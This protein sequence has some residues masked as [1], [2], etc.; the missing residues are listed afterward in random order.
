MDDLAAV[1]VLASALGMMGYSVIVEDRR[2]RWA[3]L[4]L[5]ELAKE[6]VEDLPS[7]DVTPEFARRAARVTLPDGRTVD[8]Q[9]LLRRELSELRRGDRRV[10]Q[11]S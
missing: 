7:R 2:L 4:R 11:R 6:G 5:R 8:R 10:A 9:E 3:A 1:A